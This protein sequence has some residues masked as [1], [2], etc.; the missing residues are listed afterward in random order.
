MHLAYTRGAPLISFFISVLFVLTLIAGVFG[1]VVFRYPLARPDNVVKIAAPPIGY[2]MGEGPDGHEHGK[3]PM[4]NPV[5]PVMP[6]QQQQQQ[7]QQQ[8]PTQTP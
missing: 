3:A 6:A 2:T 7:Q 5:V 8:A 4:G 1:D